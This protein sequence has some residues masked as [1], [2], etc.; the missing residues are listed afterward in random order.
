MT[1]TTFGVV[2]AGWR[3]QYFLRLAALLPERFEVVGVVARRA[4]T[5]ARVRQEW[6]VATFEDV[7]RLRPGHLWAPRPQGRT[8]PDR[9]AEPGPAKAPDCSLCG[10][11][12]TNMRPC[13]TCTRQWPDPARALHWAPS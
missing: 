7:G 11:L 5:A 13:A 12:C 2:G 4:E 8:P 6:A 3:S 10:R 1:P 9:P